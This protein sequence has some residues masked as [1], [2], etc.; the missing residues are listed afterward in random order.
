MLPAMGLIPMAVLAMAM[1]LP[2][3]MLFMPRFVAMLELAEAVA[4]DEFVFRAAG[5]EQQ[6]I[7]YYR[8]GG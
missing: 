1:L 4:G 6:W 2:A 8:V 7:E 5:S 3:A